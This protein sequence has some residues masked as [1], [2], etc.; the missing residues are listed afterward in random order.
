MSIRKLQHLKKEI[1]SE[2]ECKYFKHLIVGHDYF[3]SKLEKYF[4]SQDVAILSTEE[5]I[6]EFIGPNW[7][8]GEKNIGLIQQ[9]NPS[10]K[11]QR[12]SN[13]PCFYKEQRFREFASRSKP[14]LLL[15]GEAFY[16][17][18]DYYLEQGLDLKNSMP[19]NCTFYHTFPVEIGWQDRLWKIRCS[20]GQ[21]FECRK[22]YWG[23]GPNTFIH[24][25]KEKDCFGGQFIE[26]C[27]STNAPLSLLIRYSLTQDVNAMKETFFIPLSQSYDWGHFVGEFKE[28]GKILEF[29]HYLCPDESSEEDVSKK[30]KLLKKSLEK[31]F[32]GIF[33]DAVGEYIKLSV[34]SPCESIDDCKYVA[35]ENLFFFGVN[36]PV[37]TTMTEISHLA[38]GLH[39]LKMIENS[40][41]A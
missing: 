2:T 39:S 9:L 11:L 5:N 1:A 13:G 3:T 10:W 23:D 27:E 18:W 32:P 7:L 21:Q 20:D 19:M 24:L 14:S 37:D 38:R 41:E 30:I 17:Q 6:Q 33:K 8:R 31:I 40:I 22:L 29:V 36:A 12:K 4:P 26:F 34:D 28:N 15:P 35:V 16:T 25:L